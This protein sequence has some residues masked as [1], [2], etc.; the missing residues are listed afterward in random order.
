MNGD[1]VISGLELD[2][3]SPD[4]FKTPPK[5]ASKVPARPRFGP[6]PRD[7][8]TGCDGYLMTCGDGVYVKRG[9]L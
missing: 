3:T 8:R 1:G 2:T 9:S 4:L 6:Y 5:M 7:L